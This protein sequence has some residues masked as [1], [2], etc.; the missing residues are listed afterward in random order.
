MFTTGCPWRASPKC[1]PP[2]WAI[3][4][5]SDAGHDSGLFARRIDTLRAQAREQAG[6]PAPPTAAAIDSL[7]GCATA[8]GGPSGEDVGKTV[9]GRKRH[10]TVDGEGFP[11]GIR[12]HAVDGLDRDAAPAGILA[13]LGKA[14]TVVMRWADGVD[15]RSTAALP[16]SGAERSRQTGDRAKT[17]CHHGRCGSVLSIIPSPRGL[18]PA[19]SIR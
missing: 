2:M 6:R 19:L 15:P 11:I 8:R 9:R 1:C 5:S 4:N 18:P 13:M 3:P 16:A 7:S 14:S 12:V 17:P 10:R